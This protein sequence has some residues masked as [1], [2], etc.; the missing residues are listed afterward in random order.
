MFR[1]YK[2]EYPELDENAMVYVKAKT[3]DGY[4]VDL[5]EYGKEGHL[6]NNEIKYGKRRK[7]VKLIGKKM[8]C[9]V[10]RVDNGIIDISL[11]K[12]SKNMKKELYENY[13]KYECI[14]KLVKEAYCVYRKDGNQDVIEEFFKNTI[15][16][17]ME[18]NKDLN[19]SEKYEEIINDPGL[20]FNK[21]YRNFYETYGKDVEKRRQQQKYI[22]ESDFKIITFSGLEILKKI[23]DIELGTSDKILSISPPYYKIIIEGTNYDNLV[24][25]IKNIKETIK[26]N[27]VKNNADCIYD[28]DY[29]IKIVK[30]TLPRI[31]YISEEILK[32]Y[33]R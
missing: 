19:M 9:S 30:H 4:I 12:V 28:N 2:N 23:L 33:L 17:Y 16:E 31:K 15:W 29:E 21:N 5:L 26:R 14:F 8:L 1:Y 10:I 6:S 13:E 24:E 25:R 27:I 7:K 3:E 11:K 32:D 18:E 20:L 22:L